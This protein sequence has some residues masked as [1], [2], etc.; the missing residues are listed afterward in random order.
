MMKGM[1][2]RLRET[3]QLPETYVGLWQ[4]PPLNGSRKYQPV[5]Q[6]S[7]EP[8]SE[9]VQ[10]ELTQPERPKSYYSTSST[11]PGLEDAHYAKSIAP[12][13]EF[14]NPYSSAGDDPTSSDNASKSAAKAEQQAA[15]QEALARRRHG[16]SQPIIMLAMFLGLLSFVMWVM[17]VTHMIMGWQW[18]SNTHSN[19]LAY[20]QDPR[21]WSNP[22]LIGNMPETCLAWLTSK[23]ANA[24]VSGGFFNAVTQTYWSNLLNTAIM[25]IA[26]KYAAIIHLGILI[27]PG[28]ASTAQR[29]HRHLRLNAIVITGYM[30][31]ATVGTA[32]Y[33]GVERSQKK[34]DHFMYTNNATLTGGC[35]FG[36]V[37]AEKTWGYLDIAENLPLRLALASLGL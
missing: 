35:S 6:L 20:L 13:G 7:E 26:T 1:R 11:T 29:I 2:L 32:I 36:V 28:N 18:P 15:L 8:K 10:S 30:A 21:T 17:S 34:Q 14:D 5:T 25:T 33:V 24:F 27:N 23:G 16:H 4:M 19:T 37:Q 3:G 12:L 31:I 22:A 9:L